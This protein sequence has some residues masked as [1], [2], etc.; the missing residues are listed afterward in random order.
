MEYMDKVELL[1]I[2]IKRKGIELNMG[3]KMEDSVGN[4]RDTAVLK[5]YY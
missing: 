3:R 1:R 4:P 5:I 2:H